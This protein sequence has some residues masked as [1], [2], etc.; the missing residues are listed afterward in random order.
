[1]IDEPWRES[2][3]QTGSMSSDENINR[4]VLRLCD[5]CRFKSHFYRHISRKENIA[6]READSPRWVHRTRVLCRTCI[7]SGDL[8]EFVK[9]VDKFAVHDV[10][11]ITLEHIKDLRR[12]G[13][14]E[15][16]NALLKAFRDDVQKNKCQLAS[17]LLKKDHL[18]KGL[19]L[20]KEHVCLRCKLNDS[21]KG[22]YCE[23]CFAKIRI[24]KRRECLRRGFLKKNKKN[25]K[26][27]NGVDTNGKE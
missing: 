20:R 11:P 1:M 5:N 17:E 2:K 21:V 22:N 23:V 6:E 13:F 27:N 16:A 3:S 24:E 9:P 7:E 25:K 14:G 4:D 26:K 15:D 19:L 12:R 8:V 10:T 18:I